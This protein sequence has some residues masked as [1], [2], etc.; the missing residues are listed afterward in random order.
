MDSN[1]N[2]NLIGFY[3]NYLHTN[4]QII[5]EITNIIRNQHYTYDNLLQYHIHSNSNNINEN[6]YRNHPHSNFNT[7]LNSRT[8][9]YTTIL[10]N[11]LNNLHNLNNPNNISNDYENLESVIIRPP[12]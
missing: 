12:R 5:R 3:T 9:D 4:S 6:R 8:A 7:Y 10:A 11:E 1:Y 2:N